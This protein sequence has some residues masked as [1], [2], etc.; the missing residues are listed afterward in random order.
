MNCNFTFQIFSFIVLVFLGIEI[1]GQNYE[2][3][4]GQSSNQSGYTENV[5]FILNNKPWKSSARYHQGNDFRLGSNTRVYVSDIFFPTTRE[6]SSLEMEWDIAYPKTISIKTATNYGKPNELHLFESLNQGQTWDL[7]T[8]KIYEEN[9]RWYHM[10][11]EPKPMARYA[12]VVT[13]TDSPRIRLTDVLIESEAPT[14]EIPQYLG[15]SVLNLKYNKPINYELHYTNYPSTID[16]QGLAIDGV[17]YNQDHQTI[18]GIPLQLGLNTVVLQAENQYGTSASSLLTIQVEKGD[19]TVTNLQNLNLKF[20]T[21]TYLLPSHTNQEAIISYQSSNLN[22]ITVNG[23]ELTMQGVGDAILT[24]SADETQNYSALQGQVTIRVE[25]GVQTLETQLIDVFGSI[26]QV[27]NVPN[28]ITEQGIEITYQSSNNDI[29]EIIDNQL[30]FKSPGTATIDVSANGTDNYNSFNQQFRAD[31][32]AE[33]V[34]YF[35]NFSSNQIPN[36]W[37]FTGVNIT[38]G[39]LNFNT[40]NGSVVLPVPPNSLHLQFDL[41]RSSTASS[42]FLNVYTSED[43]NS[44]EILRQFTVFDTDQFQEVFLHLPV[45]TNFIKL[46]KVSNTTAYWRVDHLKIN[47][48][49]DNLV[50]ILEHGSW[51]NGLPAITKPVVLRDAYV[52][53]EF[54]PENVFA[55]DITLEN[56]GSLL[57]KSN[58]NLTVENS[59]ISSQDPLDFIVEP[60]ANLIQLAD[61]QNE[62][63]VTIQELSQPMMRNDM[64][65]WASPVTGQYIRQ[66][67]PGTLYNRFWVYN[68]TT[69]LYKTIFTTN[70]SDDVVFNPAKGVAIRLKHGVAE[71]YNESTLAEFKG[72]L[73]NGTYLVDVTKEYEGYNLIGNPYPSAINLYGEHSVFANP[74][75]ST[76]YIW[77]PYFKINSSSFGNN[78]ITINRVGSTS[79]NADS[80]DVTQIA[81]GQ[82]FFVKL[83]ESTSVPFEFNNLMRSIEPTSL[84]FN[85]NT[86]HDRFWIS[87]GKNNELVNRILIGYIDGGTNLVD[88]QYDAKSIEAGD[89][90]LYSLIN[91][92]K[93]SIQGRQYPFDRMDQINLGLK[94]NQANEYVIRLEKVEGIFD[95]TQ[96]VWLK[97]TITGKNHNLSLKDY[98]FWSEDGQFDNRFVIGYKEALATDEK[99]IDDEVL[100]YNMKNK[101]C[102]KSLTDNNIQQIKLFSINGALVYKEF[103]KEQEKCFSAEKGSYIIQLKTVNNLHTA[104]VL[105]Y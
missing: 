93:Y 8:T 22:V 27:S 42:R 62:G 43:G 74:N 1:N 97:D 105:V 68:E 56:G 3:N 67:S 45:N 95:A 55:K 83:I 66:F 49:E 39:S 7:V 51:S 100:I 78:Y 34:C 32:L 9:L 85:T 25:K 88:E 50:T 63:L 33:N 82:G 65:Q 70:D 57:L 46:E 71:D 53:G 31:A 91:Q 4:F 38:S 23:N 36:N 75:I 16:V 5:S 41:L 69:S 17:F 72:V 11:V 92:D 99:N 37:V 20:H 40:H 12:F 73:N 103:T 19:Q 26:N 79:P 86:L 98:V 76:V 96:Q 29:V 54:N 104:P 60:R 61:V 102:Y 64:T 13:G 87:L 101:L 28:L 89:N 94:V 47:C 81:K 14:Q 84:H 35:E 52:I 44:F 18:T 6:G 15:S 30:V 80:D 48:E 24:F 21:Q 59:I 58:S 10:N 2:S 77:T 90:Y